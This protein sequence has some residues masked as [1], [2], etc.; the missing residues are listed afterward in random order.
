MSNRNWTTWIAEEFR[1]P[2]MPGWMVAIIVIGVV[3]TWVPLG[4]IFYGRNAMSSKPRVHLI[5]DMDSQPRFN[6]QKTTALFN[7]HR[8]MRPPVPGTVAQGELDLDDHYYR[9]FT[10]RRDPKTGEVETVYFS[11]MPRQITVDENFIKLGRQKFD[12]YC[13]P[14]H[15]YAG[16]GDGP[17]NTRAQELSAADSSANAWV[18]AKNL[19]EQNEGKLLYGPGAYPDGQVFSVITHGKNNMA[20]YGSQTTPKERWAIVAYMRALQL[21]QAGEQVYNAS[22]KKPQ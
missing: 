10:Q 2:R 8:T 4:V 6:T 3:A 20:G 16:H 12:T 18:T 15:G 14:C 13:F 19:I 22:L 11:G 7:D 17:V 9:G 1:L 5:Q 21:S